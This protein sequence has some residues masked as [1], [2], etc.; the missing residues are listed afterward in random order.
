MV[1]VVTS[2]KKRQRTKRS[3]VRLLGARTPAAVKRIARVLLGD[4]RRARRRLRTKGDETA[5]HDFR[6]AVRRLR[7]TLQ[8]YR[9]VAGRGMTQRKLRR[10]LKRLAR[11]TAPAR[12]AEVGL[13]WLR[14][15]RKDS[16]A[17]ERAACGRLIADWKARRDASYK[18]ARRAVRDHFDALEARMSRALSTRTVETD[19]PSLALSIG[20]LVG[21]QSAALATELERITSALDTR[22]IHAARIEGKRLRYL[23]EPFAPELPSAVALVKSLKRFQDEFGELCDRQVLSEDLIAVAGR[24][25]SERLAGEL[26]SVLQ[27][28]DQPQTSDDGMALGL[29]AL[30]RRLRA[31]RERRF[32]GVARRYLGKHAE[33]FLTP[34]RGLAENLAGPRFLRDPSL[35]APVETERRATGRRP[36][37]RARRSVA[38][39]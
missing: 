32:A 3:R 37:G 15:V 39:A 30:A 33:A 12:D 19:A 28:A 38:A 36:S 26:R 5:L 21:V 22:A 6:V 24:Y 13:A 7:S 1:A 10:G 35:P 8:M 27:C 11:A 4:L 34:C 31:E 14:R 20:R 29:L 9:P 23:L 25:D 2:K 17:A 16:R 18:D